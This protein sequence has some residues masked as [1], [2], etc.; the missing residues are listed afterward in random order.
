MKLA[1]ALGLAGIGVSVQAVAAQAD[2]LSALKSEIEGLTARVAQLESQP[3]LPAGE[4]LISISEGTLRETPGVFLSNRERLSLQDRATY[5]S[6]L[7]TADTPAGP[8]ISWSGYIYAGVVYTGIRRDGTLKTYDDTTGILEGTEKLDQTE[9]GGDVGGH[10]ELRVQAS[11]DTS[12]GKV[13]AEL[14]LWGD[15]NGNGQNDLYAKVA[16]GYWSM[17][18]ELTLAGGYNASLGYVNFGYDATCTCYFTDNADVS[19]DPGDTSQLQL[20][21]THGGYSAAVAVEDSSLDNNEINPGLLGVAGQMSYTGDV[22]AGQIAG[23][24][25]DSNE[26]TTG[27]GSIWQVGVGG[28]VTL[29]KIASLS[30]AA[31]TGQGPYLVVSKEG[32]VV[33]GLAYDNTWWGVNGLASVNFSETAHI[34]V[35]AGY[36]NRDGDQ[37]QYKG[38]IV[39]SASY[40]VYAV[41]GGLYYT[42]VDQL[43]LGIEAEWSSESINVDAAAGNKRYIADDHTDTL[44]ADVAANWAFLTISYS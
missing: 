27:A 1:M 33:N 32:T 6:V 12:V 7:P 11:N 34:E 20:S 14:K 39:N 31:A 30:V 43:T 2:D 23:V 18:P 24:W 21:Y 26:Q 13:G 38:Y 3:A 10:S 28:S 40:D 37:K 15:Y 35:A 9:D 22:F 42:P 17:T 25:R 29:G 16:W 41:M 5:L 19:F 44:T 4:R 8:A 36:K